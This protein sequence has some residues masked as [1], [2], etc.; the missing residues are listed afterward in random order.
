MI[1]ASTR[2]L[3]GDLFEYRDLGEIELKAIAEPVSAWQAC[4]RAPLPAGLRRCAARR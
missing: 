3:T 1:A 4:A 2:R